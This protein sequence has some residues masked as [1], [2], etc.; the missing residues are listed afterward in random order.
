VSDVSS[1]VIFY[2]SRVRFL[3]SRAD[4]QPEKCTKQV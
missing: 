4:E 3:N 2:D 1:S